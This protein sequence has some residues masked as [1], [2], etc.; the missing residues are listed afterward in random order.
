[1]KVWH[2]GISSIVLVSLVGCSSSGLSSK[3]VDYRSAAV[4]MPSLEVPPDLMAWR[5]IPITVKAA[6]PVR[7]AAVSAQ[8]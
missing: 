2:V 3:R 4:Q 1:M 7:K 5:L 8:Y 6:Q